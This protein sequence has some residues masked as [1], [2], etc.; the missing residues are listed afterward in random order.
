MVHPPIASSRRADS[1]YMLN[2]RNRQI[3]SELCVFVFT[4][5]LWTPIYTFLYLP[6]AAWYNRDFRRGDAH[7][8]L[9]RIKK[10]TYSQR[11]AI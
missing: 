2:S 4:L 6:N 7:Q 5:Y 9:I 1:E 3:V 10:P 11:A 8:K